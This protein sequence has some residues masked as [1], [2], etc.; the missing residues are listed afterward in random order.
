[1]CKSA[2]DCDV[3]TGLLSHHIP[4]CCP[5]SAGGDGAGHLPRGLETLLPNCTTIFQ[6]MGPSREAR[7]SHQVV[8][9]AEAHVSLQQGVPHVCGPM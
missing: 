7:P 9:L 3:L 6:P 2:V 1:M 8:F 4:K 5:R